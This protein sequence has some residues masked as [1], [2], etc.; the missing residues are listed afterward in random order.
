MT[1]LDLKANPSQ[2]SSKLKAIFEVL[3]AGLNRTN[4]AKRLKMFGNVVALRLYKDGL[5]YLSDLERL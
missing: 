2:F 1:Y 3:M 5:L 4:I